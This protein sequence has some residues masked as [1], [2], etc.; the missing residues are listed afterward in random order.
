MKKIN[1]KKL[2][3]AGVVGIATL[4]TTAYA[5]NENE[6]VVKQG[7]TLS[8]IS[9]DLFGSQD[10]VEAL[11][12]LN[13]IQNPHLIHVGQ[14]L[15]IDGVKNLKVTKTYQTIEAETPQVADT[16][17]NVPVQYNQTEQTT[18][19]TQ[20]YSGYGAGSVQLANGNTAGETGAYAAAEM[21]KRT[22]VP[23]STWEYIIARE[24]N[25]QANAYNP[26]GASG[27]FQTMPFHGS[28]ATVDDQINSAVNA[29][30]AQGLGAWSV[31]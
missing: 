28:T 20:S 19:P 22:G 13:N 17:A 23:A 5:L 25:G 12:Q 21:E 16:T 15:I 1:F 18:V 10:Y 8:Q 14:R 30:N 27:L 29:Y 7:D 24:S 3:I 2:A 26:S 4:G 9:Q 11:A 6:Y 31:Y